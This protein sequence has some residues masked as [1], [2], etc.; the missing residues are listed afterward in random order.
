[1]AVAVWKRL[2]NLLCRWMGR[3]SEWRYHD[4]QAMVQGRCAHT[5]SGWIAPCRRLIFKERIELMKFLIEFLD[6]SSKFHGF[7]L[8]FYKISG[9]LGEFGHF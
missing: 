6:K 8:K 7:F 2:H 4:V 9:I 5:S 3:A 1:M